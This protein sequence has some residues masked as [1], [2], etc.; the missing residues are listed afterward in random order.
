MT[1]TMR[2]S[3]RQDDEIH[4]APL[5]VEHLPQFGDILLDS[6]PAHLRPYLAD[7]QPEY[8]ELLRRI[9]ISPETHPRHRLRVLVTGSGRL[10]AFADVRVDAPD[11]ETGFVSLLVVFRQFRGRGL[12]SRLFRQ[13]AQE[14]AEMRALEL[15][16][17]ADNE[18]AI[19][20]YD[21][22][23]FRRTSTHQWLTRAVPT[24]QEGAAPARPSLTEA[25]EAAEAQHVRDELAAVGSA[26]LSPAQ[27]GADADLRLVGDRVIQ[28]FDIPTFLDTDLLSAVV[29][30]H[31]GPRT[32]LLITDDPTPPDAPD[33]HSINTSH[34][35]RL[36]DLSGLRA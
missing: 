29:A 27:T 13:I 5:A 25:A 1:E 22:L 33:V 11:P 19:R 28:A 35:M 32:A 15:D 26:R 9:L 4:W 30:A 17:F 20:L 7:A 23:G 14:F 18:P 2:T 8:T 24:L 36:S 16:V 3:P 34:R 12:A 10:A 21:S 31:G 6:V